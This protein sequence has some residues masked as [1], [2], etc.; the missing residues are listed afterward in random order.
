MKNIIDEKL[1]VATFVV[2]ILYVF[3]FA[4]SRIDLIQKQNGGNLNGKANAAYT[5]PADYIEV[6]DFCIQSDLAGN[7]TWQD[8]AKICAEDE[9]ARLCRAEELMA[10]CQT[11]MNDGVSFGDN[12]DGPDWEWADDIVNAGQAVVLF[13]NNNSCKEIEKRATISS[14]NDFRCCVNRY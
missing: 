6:A 10:A 4:F 11:E 2:C 1:A 14:S 13:G 5:C 12:I 8:A 7:E 3:I 9:G